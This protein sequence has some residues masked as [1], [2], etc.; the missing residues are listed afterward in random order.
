LHICV[1]Y[2][3]VASVGSY[4]TGNPWILWHDM[5]YLAPKVWEP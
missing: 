5:R 1:I 2:L 3:F 4:L